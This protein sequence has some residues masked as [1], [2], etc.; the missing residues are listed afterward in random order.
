MDKLRIDI[1]KA[2]DLYRDYD[3]LR[4]ISTMVFQQRRILVEA[5]AIYCSKLGFAGV[6]VLVDQ[7]DNDDDYTPEGLF[8]SK[9]RKTIEAYA[10]HNEHDLRTL[11][12]WLCA[13]H[14]VDLDLSI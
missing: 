9:H 8:A 14:A 1:N 7:S 4:E 2:L 6:V 11:M 3:A 5:C 10:V 12:Q 13:V